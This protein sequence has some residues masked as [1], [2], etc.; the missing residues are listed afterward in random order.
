M[1]RP[2][3]RAGR[4][5][6]FLRRCCCHVQTSE[7]P[8]TAHLL[9]Q[10]V[11]SPFSWLLVGWKAGI[12]HENMETAISHGLFIHDLAQMEMAAAGLPRAELDVHNAEGSHCPCQGW[13]HLPPPGQPSGTDGPRTGFLE[14]GMNCSRAG[15]DHSRWR[16]GETAHC[17]TTRKGRWLLGSC[18]KTSIFTCSIVH[19]GAGCSVSS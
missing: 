10:C 14:L 2:G 4:E 18:N 3:P 6:P 5:P 8:F 7:H 15:F 19:V 1:L 11:T 13:V 12:C 17:K 9:S 16:A